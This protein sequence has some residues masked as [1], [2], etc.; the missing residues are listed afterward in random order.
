M[1]FKTELYEVVKNAV[2]EELRKFV[3]MELELLKKVNYLSQGVDESNT[4]Y[5]QDDQCKNS[6]PWYS[7]FCTET[8][9]LYLQPKIEEVTGK[10]LYPTYTYMRLY[11]TGSDMARHTDRPSCEYSA[12]VCISNDPEPWEIYFE[13]LK[14]KEKAIYLQPGDMIVYKGD[15]LPHWRNEYKGNR[16]AQVFTHFVD[17]NGKY[18]DY[19]YDRRPYLGFPANTRNTR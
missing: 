17:A 14:G 16:Q 8:L 11:Y 15:V 7:A 3:D 13:N 6:F 2:P 9:G 18:R 19:I 12:T 4:T 10:T 1:A 5:F